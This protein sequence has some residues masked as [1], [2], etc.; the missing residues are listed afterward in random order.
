[1]EKNSINIL[2]LKKVVFD[3]KDQEI[4][5][6]PFISMETK[7]VLMQGYI[8]SLDNKE[9]DIVTNYLVAEYSL[10]GGLM[11]LNTNII[12]DNTKMD[13]FIFS[14]IWD[15]VKK[16][17]V[18]YDDFRNEIELLVN[19]SSLKNS[20]GFVMSDVIEQLKTLIGKVS[21][22]DLSKEGVAELMK[23]LNAEKNDINKIID[24][25]K[26]VDTTKIVVQPKKSRKKEILQ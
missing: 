20:N 25:S 11:D 15:R 18:N 4:I 12:I 22:M 21:E 5:V 10:I 16:S 23:T 13:D 8:D 17:I 1:M 6:D 3:Y 26:Y 2:P 24:P 9:S 14:G 19:Y 7:K